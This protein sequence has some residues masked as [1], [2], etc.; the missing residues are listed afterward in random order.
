MNYSSL[1]YFLIICFIIIFLIVIIYFINNSLNTKFNYEHFNNE[2]ENI[3]IYIGI[4][5][6]PARL[7]YIHNTLNSLL[8]QDIKPN[9]IYVFIPQKSKRF[10]IEYDI[11]QIKHNLINDPDGII[12]YITGINDEGPITKFYKLLDLVPN[13]N[14]NYLFLADDDVIYPNN[15]ISNI[16][17]YINPNDIITKAHGVSGRV[18]FNNKKEKLAFFNLKIKGFMYVDILE[19]FDM[20]AYPRTIF[21]DNSNEFLKWLKQLPKDAFYVDD[22]VLS[23]WC[24]LHNCKR[25]IYYSDEKIKMYSDVD[26]IPQE[27]TNHQLLTENLAGGRNMKIYKELF[28][29]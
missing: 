12:E 16:K 5:T 8:E 9:K 22:I 21:P 3:N 10:N 13:D 23:Y 24:K 11:K 1:S 25:V 4:T 18:Y 20:V 17:K 26:N 29:K 28:M 2:N 7:P 27:V 15:R 6:I 19:A 14:N